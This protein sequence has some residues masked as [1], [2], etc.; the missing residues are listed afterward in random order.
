[1]KKISNGH[2]NFCEVEISLDEIIK[3]I[4]SEANNKSPGNDGP[5]AEFYKLFSNELTPVL[6]DVYDS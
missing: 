6:L 4:H 5:T 3:C 2:F 1:M